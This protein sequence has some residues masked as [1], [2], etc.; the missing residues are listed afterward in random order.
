MAYSEFPVTL[1]QHIRVNITGCLCHQT[2]SF[3]G[4][5]GGVLAAKTPEEW[6]Q[7]SEHPPEL[8]VMMSMFL[9][10]HITLFTQSLSETRTQ[11]GKM[12]G[13]SEA[14][15]YCVRCGP[16]ISMSHVNPIQARRPRTG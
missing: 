4:L 11:C 6:N 1:R 10:K 3:G 8:I 2:R 9:D 15:L 16:Y 13:S 5:L 14:W 7:V 12:M